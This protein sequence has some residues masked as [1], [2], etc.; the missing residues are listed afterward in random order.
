MTEQISRRLD[1]VER[2]LKLHK[3]L[4]LALLLAIGA[5]VGAMAIANIRHGASDVIHAKGL[6]IEDAKGRP[7]IALGAPVHA[8]RGR[9]RTD[10]LEGIVYLDESG[11]DRLTFGSEPD[12][13]TANGIVPRRVKGVGVLIHDK[14][15]VER[16]GYSV[17]DD[18][19]A[20]LTLDWPKTGEGVALTSNRAFSGVGLFYRSEPGV[21]R[22]AIGLFATTGQERAY[23][24]LTDTAGSERTT[25]TVEGTSQPKLRQYGPDGE[26][27]QGR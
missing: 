22:D 2:S 5:S 11:K 19:S 10:A 9:T 26:E 6:V 25:L 1:A 7:R 14:D 13:M 8:L 18:D 20:V 3:A 21:Y 12:P 15:G 23:L 16:G 17:L 27:I 4:N 24:K